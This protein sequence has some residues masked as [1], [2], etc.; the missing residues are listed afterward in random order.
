MILIAMFLR[1]RI[2]AVTLNID[3]RGFILSI[4]RYD[5]N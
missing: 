4:Y 2:S 3:K 5:D 1:F